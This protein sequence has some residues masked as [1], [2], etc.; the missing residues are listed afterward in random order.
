MPVHLLRGGLALLA[1]LWSLELPLVSLRHLKVRPQL[2]LVSFDGF[3]WD[4]VN[5]VPTPNFHALMEEGVTVEHVENVYITKTFPNHYSMVTG[6][7][8]ESHGIVGD[9]MLDPSL[10]L[11]FSF[12]N[13]SIYESH[14]WEQAEPL[15]V[16]IQKYGGRSGAA[17]WPGSD[18]KIHGMY[19]T[20]YLPRDASLSF[21][22]RVENLIKW[23]SALDQEAVNFGVLHWG[24][25]DASGHKFGPESTLMD[26]VIADLDEKLG[27]LRNKLKTA[28]LYERVNLVVT[29]DHG[30]TQVFPDKIIELD[31]Y[32]GR[33]LYSWVDNSPVMGIL[34]REGKLDEVYDKLVD[35]NPYMTVYR[36][37]AIPE[38]FHYRHN[39]RIMP[40]LL[41]AQEGWIIVQNRSTMITLGNHGYDNTLRSMQPIFLARGPAFCQNYVK[42]TMR[43]VDLYPLMCHI[44]AVPPLPNNGSLLD[45]EDLLRPESMAFPPNISHASMVVGVLI[46]AML[47]VGFLLVF[48]RQVTLKQL[49]SLRHIRREMSQPLL[50]DDLNL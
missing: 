29:S 38:R 15:W 32:V 8:A 4:Y 19:P 30:M 12:D 18:V 45:V 13:N 9:R 14:W 35:A 26:A 47:V 43:T 1:L 5:R 17:M 28:G 22:S 25:P 50:Q 33:D 6:L 49:P 3:R 40:I 39:T 31:V 48:V 10:N 41:E 11:Y 21:E 34:P 24:E 20:H 46:G 44:L 16:T 7:H 36:K 37:D 42:P 27:F 23:F 2:L